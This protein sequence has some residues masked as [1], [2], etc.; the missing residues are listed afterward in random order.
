MKHVRILTVWKNYKHYKRDFKKTIQN[1][2]TIR[3]IEELS[4]DGAGFE[5]ASSQTPTNTFYRYKYTNT[6]IHKYINTQI[7]KHSKSA[8][9]QTYVATLHRQL[10]LPWKR[11]KTARSRNKYSKTEIQILHRTR[12]NTQWPCAFLWVVV[13][14]GS[15][16]LESSGRRIFNATKFYFSTNAKNIQRW[17]LKQSNV[18]FYHL[19][20]F[21]DLITHHN[22][23]LIIQ[24]E[25]LK[26][27]FDIDILELLVEEA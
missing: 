19:E 8:S 25:V 15:I 22:D 23:C 13:C 2:L 24:T 18:T 1:C 4:D 5:S 16:C 26:F 9:N 6:Q 14:V 3:E 11:T 27:S 12:T 7:Q 21:Y 10:F 20:D 17:V